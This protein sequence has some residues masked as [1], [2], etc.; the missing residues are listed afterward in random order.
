MFF[1]T[2]ETGRGRSTRHKDSPSAAGV[3]IGRL[4]RRGTVE[5]TLGHSI[6]LSSPEGSFNGREEVAG[7]G[8]NAR[9][10]FFCVCVGGRI[11]HQAESKVEAYEGM[12][13]AMLFLG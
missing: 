4:R 3:D 2:E 12:Q 5:V 10:F 7:H 11:W 13:V 6:G 9:D 8:K 1:S